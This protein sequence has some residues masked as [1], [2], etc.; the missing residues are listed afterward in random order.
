MT[1]SRCA[2]DNTKY[3]KTSEWGPLVW[4]I[5]HTLAEK[6]GKQT[7]EIM[8]VDEM[9]IW[10]LLL[11]TLIPIIPCEECREHAGNYIKQVPFDLPVSYP[12]WSLYIRTYFYTFH[13]NVNMRLEKPSFPFSSLAETY[14]STRELTKWTQDLNAMMLRAMKLNGMHMKAWQTWQNHLRMLSATM[15]I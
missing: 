14:K 5:L 7:N 4:K 3:P 12:A 1:C 10:P 6:A 2:S 13:E 11:K 9:R 15:G 8:K